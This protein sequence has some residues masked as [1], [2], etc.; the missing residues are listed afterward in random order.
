VDSELGEIPKGGEWMQFTKLQ[1][2][3]MVLLFPSKLFNSNKDG[4]PLIRIRDLI[5]ENP[6]IWT[7]EIHPKGY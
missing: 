2:L 1:M 6:G 4:K 3:F 5:N 7:A